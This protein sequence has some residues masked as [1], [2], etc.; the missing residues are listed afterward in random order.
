MRHWKK[1]DYTSNIQTVAK[2]LE[3][4]LQSNQKEQN[5]YLHGLEMTVYYIN[6]HEAKNKIRKQLKMMKFHETVSQPKYFYCH[7]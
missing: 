7:F 4:L 6:G 3:E 1:A 2:N 5:K